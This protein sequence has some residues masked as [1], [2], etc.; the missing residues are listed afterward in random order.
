MRHTKP[1]KIISKIFYGL[2]KNYALSIKLK[3]RKKKERE[4]LQ[5][6]DKN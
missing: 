3:K 2:S 6:W 5:I 1:K 4:Q